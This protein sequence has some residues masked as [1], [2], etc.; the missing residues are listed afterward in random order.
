MD[1]V[2]TIYDLDILHNRA[3][4]QWVQD[5]IFCYPLYYTGPRIDTDRYYVQYKSPFI[6]ILKI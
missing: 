1:T 6:T 4:P 3:C 5:T 2:V